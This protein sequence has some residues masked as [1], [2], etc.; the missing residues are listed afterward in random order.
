LQKAGVRVDDLIVVQVAS[1]H[2]FEKTLHG[3]SPLLRIVFSLNPKYM[4]TTTKPQ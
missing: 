4:T 1:V 3:M 2:P